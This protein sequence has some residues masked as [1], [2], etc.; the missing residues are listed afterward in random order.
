MP[1][2]SLCLLS[3]SWTT[4]LDL[5]WTLGFQSELHEFQSI[6][7]RR[8]AQETQTAGVFSLC[9]PMMPGCPGYVEELAPGKMSR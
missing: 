2:F 4:T 1:V 8:A 5:R 6:P 3:F 9:W 7:A